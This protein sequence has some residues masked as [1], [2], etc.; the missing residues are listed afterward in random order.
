MTQQDL[1]AVRITNNRKE[2]GSL[3]NVLYRASVVD[4]TGRVF[5]TRSFA[6]PDSCERWAAS[7]WPLPVLGSTFA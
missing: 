5:E 1:A 2:H 7:W 6:N 3:R 4:S